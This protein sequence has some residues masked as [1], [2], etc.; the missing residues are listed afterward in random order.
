MKK[1]LCLFFVFLS[2]FCLPSAHALNTQSLRY[3]FP[4]GRALSLIESKPKPRDTLTFG[5]GFDYTLNPLEFGS[6]SGGART[7]GIV[8]YLVTFDF[9][10]SYSFTDRIAVGVDIPA[11]VGR[12]VVNLTAA[13]M[14]TNFNIGDILVT[15]LVGVIDSEDN[16]LGLGFGVVPFLSLPTGRS[17]DFVGDSSVTGGVLFAGDIDLNGHYVGLN[18]GFRLRETENFQNLSVASEFL[19][20]LAYHHTI[21]PDARLDGFLEL[22]GATVLKDFWQKANA[23][24]F[25]VRGGLTKALLPDDAL[26][27]TGAGGFGAGHGFGAPDFRAVLKITYDHLVSRAPGESSVVESDIPVRIQRIEKEL[28]ELTIYYPTDGDEV[29][30]FYDQKIAAIAGILRA[31]PDLGPLYII[32]HTD[33]VGSDGYNQRL[34]ERRAKKAATSV[35]AH[36]LDAKN[37]VWLGLGEKYPVVEN[38]TDANRALNRRTLFTF[39]KPK[40]LQ[41]RYTSGGVVGYNVE[42]GKRND[43]YTEVLKELERE[44]KIAGPGTKPVVIKKYKDKSQMIVEDETEVKIKETPTAEP[45]KIRL[46]PRSKKVYETEKTEGETTIDKEKEEFFEEY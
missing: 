22:N 19:Y 5:F 14:E 9:L 32:G 29:D 36:G 39:I 31:N 20:E 27:I 16:D 13:N 37:I 40:Q 28:K 41:E 17:S 12:N 43:S 4:G 42:T 45:K 10:G 6:T 34:S 7:G 18:L 35:I 8:D 3:Y 33:D 24:P 30:P 44:K 15:G 21:V 25:E 1:I 11:H 38:S 2:L 26:K 23:S 46:E